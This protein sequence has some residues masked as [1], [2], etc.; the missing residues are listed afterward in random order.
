MKKLRKNYSVER[1]IGIVLLF[2]AIILFLTRGINEIDNTVIGYD[3]AYNATV[4]ANFAKYDEY[5]VSYPSDIIFY[6]KITTGQT[7]LVPTAILYK[8]LGI[9][10]LT[11]AIVPLLYGCG[12]FVILFVLLCQLFEK[13]KI[14][15]IISSILASLTLLS[16]FYF[17]YY[18][19]H[20]IGE[21]A[22]LFFILLSTLGI[23]LYNKKK[24]EK[25]M[26][27]SGAAII[28]TYI[29]KSS[30]IFVLITF[31]GVV[32]I[33]SFLEKKFSKKAF[34]FFAI[35]NVFSF[36]ILDL[37]KFI[38]LGGL[39][40]YI[41][42]YKDEWYNMINQSSGI[43]TTMSLAEKMGTFQTLLSKN[44][45]INIFLITIPVVVYVGIFIC[46]ILK[47]KDILKRLTAFVFLG[48]AGSSLLIYYILLGGAGL[49][50]PRRLS[51]NTIIIKIYWILFLIE[52]F[53][54]CM[55]KS[56]NQIKLKYLSKVLLACV[57]LGVISYLTILP[58][59]VIKDSYKRYTNYYE[60]P[61]YSYKL[62]QKFLKEVNEL[63]EDATLYVNDWWQE[64]D[65]TLF[66]GRKMINLKS[67]DSN[68]IRKENSY[69]IVGQ[70]FVG[71]LESIWTDWKINLKEIDKIDVDF[72][73]IT[74]P[75]ANWSYTIF[76]I[77]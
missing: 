54:V 7:V 32:F 4:S 15:H 75:Y 3:E 66:L 2:L 19:T 39:K 27:L 24:Q 62:M 63:P 53:N 21:A 67:V 28:A 69:L 59:D 64:P 47:K 6:N 52:I 50:Y 74:W 25:Y 22:A 49:N 5:K 26:L 71:D 58:L 51:V 12:C 76:E 43:D 11:S 77:S 29:T 46:N 16:D 10:D 41:K 45:V 8:L 14:C 33:A 38:Q 37:I 1:M 13:N 30:M 73:K 60:E 17:F 57:L 56:E 18:S 34:V 55:K 31:W 35:G 23:V 42:W 36:V 70:Y 44:A 40:N 20:L 48:I 68:T 65:V 9:N 72:E 61:E